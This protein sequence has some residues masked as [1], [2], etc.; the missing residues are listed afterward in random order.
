MSLGLYAI[1]LALAS[2]HHA[3]KYSWWSAF[4]SQKW[5]QVRRY[6][7]GLI[8]CDLDL[9]QGSVLRRWAKYDRYRTAGAHASE[10]NE[11]LI[12][13]TLHMAPRC[14]VDNARVTPSRPIQAAVFD[15]QNTK[16]LNCY[17]DKLVGVR[18]GPHRS[19]WWMF[20]V[21]K[22]TIRHSAPRT[23]H[24]VILTQPRLSLRFAYLRS[25]IHHIQCAAKK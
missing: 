17:A 16:H 3:W 11:R 22:Q 15:Q 24:H 7:G 18:I 12:T 21:R 25:A 14:A 1:I 23:R 6:G 20:P 10:L 9:Q 13:A 2:E 8:C 5:R 4:L 19:Q